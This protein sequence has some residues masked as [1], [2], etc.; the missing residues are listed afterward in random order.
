MIVFL[1]HLK[2]NFFWSFHFP[3][4]ELHIKVVEAADVPKM[5]TAGKSD[6]F[7]QLSLSTTSQK[8]K[9]KS[10]NNTSTPVWNEQFTLPITTKLDDILTVELY[11]KDDVSKS[12]IISKVVIQVNKIPQGKVNDSWYTMHPE[13]GVKTGGKLR[14]VVHLTKPGA[15]PFK[16]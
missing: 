10:K 15:E 9:T 11:D 1:L 8:W 3:T 6:P 16:A 4:M 5:D 12:D 7:V 14:L 13:K 2:F